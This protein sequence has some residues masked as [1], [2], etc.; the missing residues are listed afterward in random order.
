MDRQPGW[1]IV[2]TA[3]GE[4]YIGRLDHKRWFYPCTNMDDR[5]YQPGQQSNIRFLKRV[6]IVDLLDDQWDGDQM[7]CRVI[8]KADLIEYLDQSRAMLR[9]YESPSQSM[10]AVCD[11]LKARS[12]VADATTFLQ[13]L[14]AA[15]EPA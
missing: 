6:E 15:A 7:V 13:A 2:E 1:W 5:P 9:D 8:R 11:T 4:H 3:W 12:L 10:N 14:G